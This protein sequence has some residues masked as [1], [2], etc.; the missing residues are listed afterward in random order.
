MGSSG[1]HSAPRCQ[2]DDLL[3]GRVEPSAQEI[4]HHIHDV[5]P[6][7]RALPRREAERRYGIKTRLQSLLVRQHQDALVVVR[8]AEE[9]DP[10]IVLLR[11]KFLGV[12][13]SH[14]VVADLD[15]DA[16]SWVQRQ[17]D[18]GL[19][20]VS[21]DIR[22]PAR[23]THRR[24]SHGHGHPRSPLEAAM[25]D[26]HRALEAYDYD[27]ARAAFERACSLAPQA[28]RP[29]CALLDL[30]VYQ[31][32]L[33]AEALRLAD[34]LDGDVLAHPEVRAPLALAAARTG[35]GG[36]AER[37]VSELDGE[38]AA[39]VHRT[40][41]DAALAGGDLSAARS[42]LAR[43]RSAFAPDPELLA[44]E[45]RLAEAQALA[46]KPHETALGE[47]VARDDWAGAEALAR[48]ILATNPASPDARRVLKEIAT[49]ARRAEQE[50][51]LAGLRAALERGDARRAR[52]ALAGLRALDADPA[53]LASF[54]R[55]IQCIEDAQTKA[56]EQQEVD[57]VVQRLSHP[58][59]A[60]DLEAALGRYAGLAPCLRNEVRKRID[61][62]EL[63]WLEEI[64]AHEEES[65]L[66]KLTPAI[67]A[68][69]AAEG[70]LAAG[71]VDAARTTLAPHLPLLRHFRR[72]RDLV[73][74]LEAGEADA[75]RRLAEDLL[76][77]AE[78]AFEA[79]D[80][81]QAWCL[82]KRIRR[83]H[84]PEAR[85]GEPERLQRRV[86]AER[87]YGSVTRLIQRC[88][89]ANGFVSA[90]LLLLSLLD[91]EISDSAKQ[92]LQAQLVEVEARL[93]KDW[94]VLDQQ[95]SDLHAGHALEMARTSFNPAGAQIGLLP[96][97]QSAI[98]S[99][100]QDD[101][102]LARIV[103]VA[104]SEIRR[105][106]VWHLPPDLG[107]IVGQGLADHSLWLVDA[108]GRYLE[109]G[110]D[111]WL[112]QVDSSFKALIPH[113]EELAAG[114]AIPQERALWLATVAKNGGDRCRVHVFDTISGRLLRTMERECD[115]RR[116]IGAA[117][118]SVARLNYEGSVR[119][120]GARGTPMRD[121]DFSDEG[122][123]LGIAA[124]PSGEGYLTLLRSLAQPERIV[125]VV[126][127]DP[128]GTRNFRTVMAADYDRPV[129]IASV[130]PKRLCCVSYHDPKT[131]E[132]RIIYL[133]QRED[134][135]ARLD[136]VP[137][138]GTC[139]LLQDEAATTC[140]AMRR[141]RDGAVLTRLDEAPMQ[142][143]EVGLVRFGIPPVTW[144]LWCS[145]APD[146]GLEQKRHR[147]FLRE[148]MALPENED[149]SRWV[150]ARMASCAT[151]YS[152]GLCFYRFL[153]SEG[154]DEKADELLCSLQASFP[155]HPYVRLAGI[156]RDASMGRWTGDEL[157]GT[158]DD[159]TVRV[160]LIHLR[161][162]L[163]LRDN[164][165]ADAIEILSDAPKNTACG[166][167]EMLDLA[168]ALLAGLSAP[169][170][171]DDNQPTGLQ[172]LVRTI[173]WADHHLEQG[174]MEAARRLLDQAWIH[175]IGEVQSLARLAHIYLAA[176][177][178]PAA[179]FRTAA[180]LSDFVDADRIVTYAISLW[181]GK[182][183]WDNDRV[184]GVFLRAEAWLEEIYAGKR[185]LAS[186]DDSASGHSKGGDSHRDD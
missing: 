28:V 174:D 52:Q 21:P 67:V 183:T 44:L 110:C 61:R 22:Q 109:I 31:L 170:R 102:L 66:A 145:L 93:R 169:A 24:S 56:R 34:G 12:A 82:A 98:F 120:T 38:R 80:H 18:L 63:L 65:R 14:A 83:Q 121:F 167:T 68:M 13:A 100:I 113:G 137:T 43:A 40:L 20:E 146:R 116:V 94:V 45:K 36:L 175:E 104:T 54:D 64:A 62:R 156:E 124:A 11:H 2:L 162:L 86:K 79:G 29:T 6:T 46:A 47:M 30:L 151:S 7:G 177:A 131:A 186:G 97:G 123:P 85:A 136:N 78:R 58:G 154:L 184:N 141:T 161:A 39:E 108:N 160:H 155:T 88:I 3:A 127:M 115:F 15:G 159:E 111:D 57:E 53:T 147:Q 27:A 81:A 76:A 130:L 172:E 149:P 59:S 119:L 103:D 118:P 135:L 26:G 144:P 164:R 32:G 9:D 55:A 181:L 158:T 132:A 180:L 157:L 96:G 42:A 33:D 10:A 142:F 138:H 114:L 74:R 37:W 178:D 50:G 41:A 171:V 8:D 168:R 72:G 179:F 90:R 77:R 125:V 107:T 75:R 91:T 165:F 185:P 70:S 99:C 152:L 1:R 19:D 134:K 139:E 126:G 176:P 182:N 133:R 5:N 35:Q 23:P 73:A 95:R 87:A 17:I 60:H 92:G 89:E 166:L 128:R 69:G 105:L 106:L 129:A 122:S 84:L 173:L 4:I 140:V 148:Q 16:R 101:L 143:P 153:R 49:R 51:A 117:R 71:D 112:P 163:C 48:R 25:E 150:A